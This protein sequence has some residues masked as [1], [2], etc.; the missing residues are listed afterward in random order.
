MQAH[1]KREGHAS[2]H[3]FHNVRLIRC[4]RFNVIRPSPSCRFSLATI[5]IVMFIG[6]QRYRSS[7]RGLLQLSSSHQQSQLLSFRL[8]IYNRAHSYIR[9]GHS[10]RAVTLTACPHV[11]LPNQ[12]IE[13]LNVFSVWIQTNF[14]R[15]RKI[16]N[17]CNTHRNLNCNTYYIC[18]YICMSHITNN[19]FYYT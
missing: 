2:C 8:A 5:P 18:N 4:I 1:N 19:N 12:K 13:R 15:Y 17:N 6:I 11:R 7:P 3:Q 14:V 10:G 16:K 9:L